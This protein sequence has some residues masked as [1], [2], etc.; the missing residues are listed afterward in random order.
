[1]EKRTPRDVGVAILAAIVFSTAS[2]LGKLAAEIPATAMAAGRCAIAAAILVAIAPRTL[3]RSLAALTRKQKGA[4]ALAGVLLAA[5]FALFLGGLLTTSLAAAVALVALE[6]LAVV[7]AAFVAFGMKPKPREAAGLVVATVGAIVVGSG[8][9]VGEH[10]LA[11]DLLVVGAVVVFGA[12]VAAARGIRDALPALPYAASVYTIACVALL[13]FAIP[14]ALAAPSPSSKALAA[15]AGLGLLPTLVGHTLLQISARRAGPVLAALIS[16]GETVG[17][18]LI[19]TLLMGAAPSAREAAGTALV[20]A[21]ATLAV[22]A[23]R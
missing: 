17:S 20:L 5:H 19:A 18:L 2:P 22:T 10:R 12:Y 15:L 13:P 11:G 16:P 6:P 1:M 4:V 9:G 7:I 23:R 3:V 14:A 8:A 21:G